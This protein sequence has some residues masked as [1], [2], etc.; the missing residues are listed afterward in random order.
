DTISR[1]IIDILRSRRKTEGEV[2]CAAFHLVNPS[3]A[4]WDSLIP[5]IEKHFPVEI[6]DP[7]QW[8][9]SLEASTN[10]TQVDLQDKP[11]LKILD[12]FRGAFIGQGEGSSKPPVLDTQRTHTGGKCHDATAYT[13]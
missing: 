13:N 10:P 12:F 7:Q 3:P 11:P 6:V 5:A 2:R 4:P 8:V 1:V 9:A